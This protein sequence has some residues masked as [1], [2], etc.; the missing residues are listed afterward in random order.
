MLQMR[1]GFPSKTFSGD[2]AFEALLK[3]NSEFC[4]EPKKPKSKAMTCPETGFT[5]FREFL[6]MS[7][8]EYI[9]NDLC[10]DQDV[11]YMIVR[12]ACLNETYQLAHPS[13]R[14]FH[15]R[16]DCNSVAEICTCDP[17]HPGAPQG[18]DLDSPIS[19]TGRYLNVSQSW[20]G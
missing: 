10:S 9:R 7:K 20:V 12:Q 11:S 15:D 13:L 1:A 16:F 17:P 3:G 5:Q 18:C 6:S 8:T 19:K 4:S 14:F 2:S